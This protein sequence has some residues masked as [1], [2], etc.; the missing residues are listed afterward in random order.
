MT[1]AKQITEHYFQ[2]HGL[3]AQ[4]PERLNDALKDAI[5][6]LQANLYGP[7]RT[8]LTPSEVAM[9][10]RAGVDV[11]EHPERDD[12]M[13]E[14]AK[15]FAAI[16]ATSLSPVEVAKRLKLTPVRVRQL[17]RE[18]ALYAIRIEGRW[19]VPVFQFDGD[20]LVP[21]IGRVNARLAAL[22]AVSVMRWYTTPDPALEVTNGQILTPLEWL[23]TGRHAEALIAIAPDA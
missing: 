20:A 22:N 3:Q 13:L 18:H 7:S 16:L 21:N 15:E 10:E 19:H 2:V 11:D 14:Y 9:L 8:E 4:A 12:P 6:Q 1:T 5:K 17:I 23:K